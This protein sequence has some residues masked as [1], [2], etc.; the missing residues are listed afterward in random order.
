MWVRRPVVGAVKPVA[1]HTDQMGAVKSEQF[2]QK[3][4]KVL[5]FCFG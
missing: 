1:A 4:S 3:I 2:A 5:A